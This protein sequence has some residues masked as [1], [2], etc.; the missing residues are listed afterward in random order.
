MPSHRVF[1]PPVHAADLEAYSAV[2]LR[3]H[4]R[5]PGVKG[6][7]ARHRLERYAPGQRMDYMT[8][9]IDEIAAAIV[10]GLGRP[11]AYR[12]VESDGDVRAARL[13]ADLI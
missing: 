4:L 6:S 5:M 9:A 3:T 7:H 13:L 12:P 10:A 1:L 11:V 2:A 8:A